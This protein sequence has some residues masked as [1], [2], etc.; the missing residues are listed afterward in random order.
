M[1]CRP[2]RSFISRCHRANRNNGVIAYR[3][4]AV[5][6]VVDQRVDAVGLIGVG[7]REDLIGKGGG[8]ASEQFGV[9]VGNA[10]GPRL[11][12]TLGRDLAQKSGNGQE[13][14]GFEKHDSERQLRIARGISTNKRVN[15]RDSRGKMRG[16]ENVTRRRT[17]YLYTIDHIGIKSSNFVLA[18]SRMG[19]DRY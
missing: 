12:E 14:R 9:V 13:S 16:K 18:P 10:V 15:K 11:G 8:V 17:T 6:A 4:G 5:R 1:S 2:K 7:G 3:D 19:C